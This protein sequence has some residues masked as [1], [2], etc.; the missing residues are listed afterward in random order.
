MAQAAYSVQASDWSGG[1]H[2]GTE[3]G[4]GR[5]ILSQL[6]FPPSSVHSVPGRLSDTETEHFD[7][8]LLL[9]NLHY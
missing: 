6:P 3:G 9:K 7:S 4:Y 8:Y 1:R 2:R 5:L